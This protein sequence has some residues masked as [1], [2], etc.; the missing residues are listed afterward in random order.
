MAR[1]A[2]TNTTSFRGLFQKTQNV[3]L[4]IRPG[5][6]GDITGSHVDWRHMKHVPFCDSPLEVG[7]S[8]F[9][10]KDGGFLASID[11][12]NGKLIKARSPVVR[13]R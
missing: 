1:S 9:A 3:I 8:V 12:H 11:A 4:A 10:V 7:G 6:K 13:D 2:E 5:G